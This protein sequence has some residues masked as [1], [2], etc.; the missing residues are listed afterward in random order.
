MNKTVLNKIKKCLALARSANEHE[1]AAALAKARELM[2]QHGIDE[3]DI[4]LGDVAEAIARASRT[5][6]PPR[7]E[8]VLAATVCHAVGVRN[9]INVDG[10]RVFVSVHSRAEI[11][12][13][14]FS[15]LFRQL[16]R[17]RADYIKSRL[18][19]CGP[20][21]KRARAD[22][23]CEGWASGALQAIMQLVPKAE[24][25]AI[26]ERYLEKA[27]PHAQPVSSRAANAKRAENDF[28]NG[29]DGGRNASLHQ[30]VHGSTAAPLA[31]A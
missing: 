9:L 8:G 3:E 24:A 31:M 15:V 22:V 19:R 27:Y 10:D 21:R 14:A 18:K 2:D 26:V 4:G 12:G 28:H 17:A 5:L 30:A 25:G 1:A 29:Y 16:K 7:W 20:G 23:F 6:K 13:Y 11:A